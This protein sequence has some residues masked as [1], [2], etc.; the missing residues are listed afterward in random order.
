M[1]RG[2]F[3]E[4][5]G[6]CCWILGAGCGVQGAGCEVRGFLHPFLMHCLGSPSCSF[7]GSGAWVGV[8]L[9][10]F[11]FNIF[12]QSP[13]SVYSLIQTIEVENEFAVSDKLHQLYVLDAKNELVKL[14]EEGQV[15]FQFNN[16]TLGE[17]AHVDASNPFNLLLFYREYLNILV[18]DRTLN[19]TTQLNLFDL[20][21]LQVNAV[22]MA[23][24]N[25]VWIFDDFNNQLKKVN[26]QGNVILESDNLTLLFEKTIRP[27][28]LLEK[29]Q[30]VYLNDPEIGI[31]IFDVFGQFVKV[32]DFKGLDFFQVVENQLIFF[33][34]EALNSFHLQSLLMKKIA[35]PKGLKSSKR[36]LVQKNRLY[37]IFEGRIEVYSF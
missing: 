24:D 2:R 9:L 26:R 30:M 27:N 36:V 4:D 19:Q 16:N 7:R 10:F 28:F 12:S 15:T 33:D 21:I 20:N 37:G 5:E 23:N 17:L 8:L 35:L 13:D 3:L 32:L 1:K 14:N 31:I 34:N 6:S 18:L 11:Q 29:E 25:N 22:G